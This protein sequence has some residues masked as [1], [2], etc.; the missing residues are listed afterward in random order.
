MYLLT[1]ENQ[2]RTTEEM[3]QY[4]P[5]LLQQEYSY[6]VASN[7]HELLREKITDIFPLFYTQNRRCMTNFDIISINPTQIIYQ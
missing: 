2:K 4:K 6:P 3:V 5:N 1:S 7:P